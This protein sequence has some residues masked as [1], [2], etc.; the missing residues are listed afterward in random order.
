M[1]KNLIHIIIHLLV[2]VFVLLSNSYQYLG[3]FYFY[4]IILILGSDVI[5]NKKV[6]LLTTW[7]FA[8]LFI[9]LPEVFHKEIPLIEFKLIALQYLIIANSLVHIGFHTKRVKSFKTKPFSQP[10]YSKNTYAI[11]FILLLI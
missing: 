6:S 10:S 3:N 8:F 5:V 7:N 9:V 1:N 2:I 11:I 4:F